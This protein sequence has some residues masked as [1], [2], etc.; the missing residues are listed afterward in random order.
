[1][2]DKTTKAMKTD[3]R[4]KALDEHFDDVDKETTAPAAWRARQTLAAHAKPISSLSFSPSEQLL[5]SS[6]TSPLVPLPRCQI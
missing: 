3:K 5:A 6:C 2:A 4:K 1:M